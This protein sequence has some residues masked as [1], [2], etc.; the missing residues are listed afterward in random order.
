M[1]KLKQECYFCGTTASKSK[2]LLEIKTSPLI[3]KNS[4]TICQTDIP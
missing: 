4:G 3:S 2:L 1:S